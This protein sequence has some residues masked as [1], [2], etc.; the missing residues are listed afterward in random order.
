MLSFV[1][2]G[3]LSAFGGLLPAGSASRAAQ[4]MGD[5][6]LLPTLAVVMLG[7]THLLGE[8]GSYV[9]TVADVIPI[10]LLKS[11]ISVVQIEEA[12][13][14]LIFSAVIFI[15]LLI[16]RMTES[17]LILPMPRRV[18]NLLVFLAA[19]LW[20]LSFYF[21]K[22][23]MSHIGPL[24]FTGIRGAIAALALLPFVWREYRQTGGEN[25]AITRFG[26]LG[27]ALFLVA[28]GLQQAGMITATLTNTAFLTALYV[29]VT[30]FLLWLL[31][32]EQ[33]GLTVWLSAAVA[34]FGIWLLGGGTLMAFS[35]GDMLIAAS[36][37]FWSLFMVVTSASSKLGKPLHYTFVQFATVAALALP[38]AAT[39]EVVSGSAIMTAAPSLLFVG[40]IAS[41]ITYALMANVVRYIEAS[42]AAVLLST[43][44]LFAAALGYALLG[45]R[46]GAV[47]WLGAAIVF[48]A[49]LMVQLAK[50]RTKEKTA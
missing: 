16:L 25:R 50:P 39:F 43:E 29:V 49:V 37:L 48:V 6:Y 28:G 36:S 3:S 30:P 21:Q 32:G 12:G 33:P 5:A 15:M 31:R 20:G 9:G 26:I 4:I 38:L 35:S 23:A 41:A 40:V 18:A 34:F 8:H 47:N 13:R 19:F 27:G 10:T 24:L 14:Q 22:E 7:G 1:M 17:S 11:I 44:V 46:L 42:R 45:E 2:S